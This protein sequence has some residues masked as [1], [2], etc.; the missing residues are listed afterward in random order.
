MIVA[1]DVLLNGLSNY[2][3]AL[4]LQNPLFYLRYKKHFDRLNQHCI[5]FARRYRL[6]VVELIADIYDFEK[7]SA[8][9][10]DNKNIGRFIAFRVVCF[11]MI[12]KDVNYLDQCVTMYE[13]YC[14]RNDVL[15]ISVMSIAL[16]VGLIL[17]RYLCKK[18]K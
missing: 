14:C 9:F 15:Y 17:V 5:T 11:E 6:E 7:F 10:F 18:T 16:F 13:K 3:S 12:L 2:C 1:K 4:R 8:A